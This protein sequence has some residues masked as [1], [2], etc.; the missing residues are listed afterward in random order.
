MLIS[1]M[2]EVI[3]VLPQLYVTTNLDY[4]VKSLQNGKVIAVNSKLGYHAG[5]LSEYTEKIEQ[6]HAITYPNLNDRVEV[7]KRELLV[8]LNSI[9]KQLGQPLT[10][11]VVL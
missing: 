6:D 1:T 5:D 9:E 8:E 3:E 11:E 2:A 10:K 7:M 4:I